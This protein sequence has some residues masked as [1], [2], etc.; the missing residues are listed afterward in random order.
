MELII[1]MVRETEAA[2][3]CNDFASRKELHMVVKLFV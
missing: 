3:D 2:T 1:A